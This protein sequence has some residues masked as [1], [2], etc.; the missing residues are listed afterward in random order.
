MGFFDFFRRAR[1]HPSSVAPTAKPGAIQI[2]AIQKPDGSE[3]CPVGYTAL[4]DVPEIKAGIRKVAELMSVM[5]LHLMENT[6]NGNI[7]RD[8]E[9]SRKLD[10][11]PCKYLTRP[12]WIYKIVYDMLTSG[13]SYG[14]PVYS[15]SYLDYIIPVTTS[16]S[17]DPDEKGGYTVLINGVEYE[18][19]EVLHFVYNP[20]KYMPWLG[21]GLTQE[22]H[23]V[24]RALAQARKT[25]QAIM[26]S[27]MPAIVVRVDNLTEDLS[28]PEGR[29]EISERYIE[30]VDAGKP[31]VISAE[32]FELQQIKPLS[33][34]DLAI[35]D[36]IEISTKAAAAILG[37][38]AYVLGVGE[39]KKDEY[40]NFISTKLLPLAV[41]IEQELTRKLLY[42][43]SLFFRFSNRQLFSYTM[44][45]RLAF[46]T[47]LHDRGILSGN[48]VR[49]D[50][51]LEPVEG[52]DERKVLENYIPV[53][54]IGDQNKI[55]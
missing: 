19:D 47:A 23:G 17:T 5:P 34:S 10:I 20:D 26:E 27:P 21:R 15:G 44:E 41:L 53:T 11:T 22:L 42:S 46:S 9:L 24:V 32:H 36:D 52:L 39:F 3:W 43:P 37:V 45:E 49:I 6:P 18:P 25:T 12:Q 35:K 14:I 1:G 38:P 13:N 30:S 40:N 16:A 2:R 4:S 55:N 33:L 29:A 50:F 28:T 51:G 8:D 54:K 31:W 48:E 7:R